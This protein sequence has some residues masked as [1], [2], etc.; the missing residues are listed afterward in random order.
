M[1]EDGK[2]YYYSLREHYNDKLMKEEYDVEL[3]A[4]FVFINKHCFNGLYQKMARDFLMFRT[5]IAVE[6]LWMKRL[7][8]RFQNILA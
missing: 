3:A 6:R 1:W 5:T 4:L 8:W 2:A 7:L